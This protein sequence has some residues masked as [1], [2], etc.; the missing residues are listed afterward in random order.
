MGRATPKSCNAI[1]LHSDLSRRRQ[2][3]GKK[4]S[5][6]KKSTIFFAVRPPGVGETRLLAQASP[7]DWI[8]RPNCRFGRCGCECAEESLEG[9]CGQYGDL[10]PGNLI[11]VKIYGESGASLVSFVPSQQHKYLTS[12]R[13]VA[14]EDANVSCLTASPVLQTTSRKPTAGKRGRSRIATLRGS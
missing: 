3:V 10:R 4:A 14:R 12:N 9:R 7:P 8:H 13:I 2:N 11:L 5:G 6:R 1:A